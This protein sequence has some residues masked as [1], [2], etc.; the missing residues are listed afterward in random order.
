MRPLSL[1]VISARFCSVLCRKSALSALSR[2][3]LGVEDAIVCPMDFVE[4]VEAV[5]VFA[6]QGG[7]AALDIRNDGEIVLEFLQQAGGSVLIG[8]DFSTSFF[9]LASGA[10]R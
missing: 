9:P 6:Q 3:A 1:S 5:L 10:R 8:H 7:V 2:V 4:V